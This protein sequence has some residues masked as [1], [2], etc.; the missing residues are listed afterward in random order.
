MELVQEL[1]DYRNKLNHEIE[2]EFMERRQHKINQLNQEFEYRVDSIKEREEIFE[3]S[4]N[5]RLEE[6]RIMFEIE[7]DEIRRKLESLRSYEAAAI[8]ARVRMYEENNEDTFYKIN[9]TEQDILEINELEQILPHLRNGLPLRRAIFDIYY[10]GPVK[11]MINRILGQESRITGIYK[12]T[13]IETGECYVGQSVDIKSRWMQHTRR[14]FGVDEG[15]QN[16]L[17]PAMKNTDY[18]ASSLNLSKLLKKTFCPKKKNTGLN[19]LEHKRSAL[20]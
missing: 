2:E 6:S 12:I 10:R 18:I 16:K 15:T 3:K 8:D 19:T 11:D 20:A 7:Q 13:L 17:Y 14:G 5:E 1:T 4:L 9:L